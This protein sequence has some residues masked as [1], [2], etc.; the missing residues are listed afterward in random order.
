MKEEE[1]VRADLKAAG[2]LLSDTT[3]N[4]MTPSQQQL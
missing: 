1:V 4:C 3:S 2:E